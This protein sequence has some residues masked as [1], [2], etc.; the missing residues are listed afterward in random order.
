MLMPMSNIEYISFICTLVI[1]P[2]KLFMHQTYDP[3]RPWELWWMWPCPSVEGEKPITLSSPAMV[4][5]CTHTHMHACTNEHPWYKTCHV[6]PHS[7]LA[8]QPN[9]LR[10]RAINNEPIE[11][12][13]FIIMERHH[14]QRD[15]NSQDGSRENVWW[16]HDG[17]CDTAAPSVC[18]WWVHLSCCLI[19]ALQDVQIFCG[20]QTNNPWQRKERL[21]VWR[22]ESLNLWVNG[23][24]LCTYLHVFGSS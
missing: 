4:Q 17:S 21:C 11:R 16:G 1:T 22:D 20:R 12:T 5:R 8:T 2:L 3:S 9:K 15:T 6:H 13:S 24:G 10:G 7:W 19:F 18:A 14:S 23:K